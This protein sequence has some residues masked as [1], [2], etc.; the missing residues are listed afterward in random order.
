MRSGVRDCIPITVRDWHKPKAEEVE[1]G[2]YVDD[3][4]KNNLW[5]HLMAHFTLPP[6]EN[7]DI[8]RKMEEKVKEFAL[9]K[10]AEQFKNH[11]KRLCLD[12]VNQNKTPDFTGAHEKIKVHCPNS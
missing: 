10:M 12:F 5:R 7:P 1:E 8:A 4:A 6:E 11:K 9:K 3:I 2:T